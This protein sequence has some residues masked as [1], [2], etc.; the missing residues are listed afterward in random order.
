MDISFDAFRLAAST[1][2]LGDEPDAREHADLLEYRMDLADEDPLDA[3]EDYDGD[4][5]ILATNRAAWEGGEAEDDEARLDVLAE[6][7]TL[8]CVAAVDVELAAL[9]G[10]SDGADPESD[11]EGGTSEAGGNAAAVLARGRSHDVTVVVSTHDFDGTPALSD[12]GQELAEACSLGDVGKIA[13]T[14]ETKGDV[15]NLLRVTHEFTK[16]GNDVATMAMGELGRHSRVVAPQYGS[17]IGYAP[18]DP[19]EATAPGQYDLETMRRLVDEL[20]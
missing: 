12:L 4:L 3:L 8:D 13:T 6:A 19:D 15:L 5:P 20:A 14:A 17:R 10:E 2:D 1:G 9:V 7:V 18:V 16:A 11:G